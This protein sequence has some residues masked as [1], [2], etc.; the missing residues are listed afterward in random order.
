M[1][2]QALAASRLTSQCQAA[3]WSVLRS[4]PF[5]SPCAPGVLNVPA[6]LG[7]VVAHQQHGVVNQIGVTAGGGVIHAT[8]QARKMEG[9]VAASYPC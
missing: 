7:V 9:S 5:A 1:G 4:W 3:N 8:L 2:C 6:A